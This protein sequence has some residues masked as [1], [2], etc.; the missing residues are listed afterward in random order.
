MNYFIFRHGETFETKHNIPYGDR[1]RSST[2]LD[3]GIPA[4]KRLAKH[5]RGIETDANFSSPFIRCK[6]T[7]KIIGGITKNTFVFDERLAE[8]VEKEEAFGQMAKRV[9]DFVTDVE[10]EKYNNIVVCTHGGIIAGLIHLII[11]GYFEE[12]Q[13]YNFP[14]PGVLISIEGGKLKSKDFN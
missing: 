5:L 13:L 7:V 8:Y 4:L 3:E 2:I 11:E 9:K 1:V 14:K 12:H 6:Q 10:K